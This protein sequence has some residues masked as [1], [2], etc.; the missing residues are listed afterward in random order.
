MQYNFEWDPIKATANFRKHKISFE[1]ATEVF[2]DPFALSV[3]DDEHS[4]EEDRWVTLGKDKGEIALVVVH[5]F[6]EEGEGQFTVRIVAARKITR[7]ATVRIISARKAT[8]KEV[9]RYEGE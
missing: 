1:R 4:S 6:R 5:T 3:F 7:K 8:K 9:K 2:S